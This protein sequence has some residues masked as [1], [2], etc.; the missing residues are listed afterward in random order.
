MS[1]NSFRIL[2]QW[3]ANR[4]NPVATLNAWIREKSLYSGMQ[5]ERCTASFDDGRRGYVEKR[6]D[7]SFEFRVVHTN[8]FALSGD[9]HAKACTVTLDMLSSPTVDDPYLDGPFTYAGIGLPAPHLN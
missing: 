6:P 9:E 2:Q 5:A 3:R 7:G 8:G 1:D 4:K